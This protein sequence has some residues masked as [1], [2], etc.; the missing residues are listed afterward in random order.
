MRYVKILTW[1]S[2]KDLGSNGDQKQP[3]GFGNL[4]EALL[5]QCY[6]LY[7]NRNLLEDFFP[8][9]RYFE[10]IVDPAC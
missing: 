9:N 10:P 8:P 1:I 2:V 4:P 5:W 7:M 3:L 6:L